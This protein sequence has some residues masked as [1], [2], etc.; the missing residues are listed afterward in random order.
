MNTPAVTPSAAHSA[1][2]LLALHQGVATPFS[3]YEHFVVR[4][5]VALCDNGLPIAPEDLTEV[6]VVSREI[7]IDN[8]PCIIAWGI[9]GVSADSS[10][11]FVAD[12]PTKDIASAIGALL[13]E[14][15][16]SL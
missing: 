8:N 7:T 5:V 3:Q 14:H 6:A 12:C 16:R 13:N 15:I 9:Y 1:P 4:G 10:V 2:A 11:T